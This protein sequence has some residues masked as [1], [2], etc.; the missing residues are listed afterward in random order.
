MRKKGFTLVELLVVIAIIALLMGILMPA[1]ARV[2]MIAYRMVCGT[3]LAGIGKAMLLYAGDTKEAYPMTGCVGKTTWSDTGQL[4]FWY[5]Y[6]QMC[7]Q[8]YMCE[9]GDPPTSCKATI[10]SIFYMLVRYEDT[11]VK[12]FNCKGDVGVR[13]FRLN[14]FPQIKGTVEDFTKCFD[15]GLSPG[16]Y[17]SYSYHQPFS[18][19]AS[20]GANGIQ[21]QVTGS[22]PP[23]MPMAA[24]RNPTLDTNV[25]YIT[26]TAVTSPG[27]TPVSPEQTP[28]DTWTTNSNQYIDKDN[29][30]NSFAHQREGQNVLYVDGHVTF[31]KTANVGIDNDNI[32]Q[33]WVSPPIPTQP[34]PVKRERE[35]CGGFIPRGT[36]GNTGQ[37]AYSCTNNQVT[38][39][40][41][42]DSL[43]VNEPQDTGTTPVI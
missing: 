12:Q 30:Y 18:P 13:T 15:F 42:G 19:L 21:W 20:G 10:G 26:S 14:D 32:W 37:N 34:K 40:G 38:P 39:M 16:R 27:G 43:L 3:N 2:R 8:V 36:A 25:N 33:R 11:S 29:V 1:L 22:S 31:A 41:A 6:G 5:D 4:N 17:C 24:D 35:A 23:S 28:C 9:G 7:T